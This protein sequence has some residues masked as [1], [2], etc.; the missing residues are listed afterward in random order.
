MAQYTIEIDDEIVDRL[1]SEHPYCQ[2]RFLNEQQYFASQLQVIIDI[3]DDK[4]IMKNPVWIRKVRKD[5]PNE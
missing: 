2:I 5:I 4:M 1:K 3:K